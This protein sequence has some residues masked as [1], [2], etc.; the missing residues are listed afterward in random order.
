MKRRLSLLKVGVT[1]VIIEKR[2]KMGVLLVGLLCLLLREYV[3]G[4][5]ILVLLLLN[6]QFTYKKTGKVNREKRG[7]ITRS[8]G[9]AA[10]L[11]FI[12]NTIQ[13]I[14]CAVFSNYAEKINLICGY[15]AL[16]IFV[17]CML[18][19]VSHIFREQIVLDNFIENATLFSVIGY[20]VTNIWLTSTYKE[21]KWIGLVILGAL[22]IAIFKYFVCFLLR[23]NI[24]D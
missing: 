10:S 17:I 8:V 19:D 6:K 12:L 13:N 24:S 15:F 21:E 7:V 14:L 2:E 9:I 18:V 1:S 23:K 20:I 11:V 3:K 5:V 22:L 16:V 4:L